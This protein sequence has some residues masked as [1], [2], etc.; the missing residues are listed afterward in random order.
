LPS[1]D[2]FSGRST[3]FEVVSTHG[4]QDPFDR[5]LIVQAVTEEGMVLL[6]AD[7]TFEKYS[8]KSRWC[9]TWLALR[10]HGLKRADRCRTRGRFPRNRS[11]SSQYQRAMYGPAWLVRQPAERG[12]L[13][14][15]SCSLASRVSEGTRSRRAPQSIRARLHSFPRRSNPV[16]RSRPPRR[17]TEAIPQFVFRRQVRQYR[18]TDPRFVSWGSSSSWT[19]KD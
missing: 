14:L 8:V 1:F 2:L 4:H 17:S 7:R 5:I 10:T 13:L 6:T 12:S 11:F 18:W 9:G 19:W 16:R 15:A 3:H